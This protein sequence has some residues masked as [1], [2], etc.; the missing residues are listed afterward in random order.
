M[1]ASGTV[2]SAGSTLV[3]ATFASLVEPFTYEFLALLSALAYLVF[4]IVF[5]PK[6]GD[7]MRAR[8]A[9]RS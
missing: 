8:T 9:L 3:I 1:Y 4:D 2:A 7:L 5:S 6:S